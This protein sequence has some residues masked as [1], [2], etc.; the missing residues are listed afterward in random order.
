MI[1][2]RSSMPSTKRRGRFSGPVIL[3]LLLAPVLAL[4]APA[5]PTP[6]KPKATFS[7]SVK[8][9][10][11]AALDQLVSDSNFAKAKSSVAAAFDQAIA[12]GTA[13]DLD[14]FREAA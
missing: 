8:T 5:K 4:G 6:P 10:V 1:R 13:K 14:A 9:Q 2:Y 12:Y 11:T 7:A 3:C